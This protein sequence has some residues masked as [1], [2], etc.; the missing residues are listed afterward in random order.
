MGTWS[1][2]PTFVDLCIPS[3]E[4]HLTHPYSK[5]IL[6]FHWWVLPLCSSSSGWKEGSLLQRSLERWGIINEE[7]RASSHKPKC[8]SYNIGKRTVHLAHATTWSNLS[9]SLS[10]QLTALQ[11]A[12]LGHQPQQAFQRAWLRPGFWQLAHAGWKIIN[13]LKST[14]INLLVLDSNRFR[15]DSEDVGV[16][17]HNY[18]TNSQW[19]HRLTVEQK[20]NKGKSLLTRAH[21]GRWR[22]QEKKTKIQISQL[23]FIY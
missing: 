20:K 2:K 10:L 12:E 15:C 9:H 7:V 1:T 21:T 5:M 19:C 14:E 3:M 11:N 13:I 8:L 6:R 4:S 16:R 17:T 18:Q 22:L 23:G